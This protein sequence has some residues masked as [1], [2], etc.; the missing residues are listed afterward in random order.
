MV[1]TPNSLPSPR[2]HIAG[3]QALRAPHP[4]QAGTLEVRGASEQPAATWTAWQKNSEPSQNVNAA[5][6]AQS[7]EEAAQPRS[8]FGSKDPHFW[9]R[10]GNCQSTR[11]GAHRRRVM[12]AD[13]LLH[14]KEG[15]S[16]EKVAAAAAPR[17]LRHRGRGEGERRLRQPRLAEELK[18]L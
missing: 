15:V 5:G 10:T 14:N 9:E 12:S 6:P 13:Q 17:S 1:G 16:Q 7:L 3:Y 11:E 2:W 4:L 18:G 8:V